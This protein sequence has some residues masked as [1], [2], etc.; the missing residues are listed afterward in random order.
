MFILGAMGF[1]CGG[2]SAVV[3]AV[4]TPEMI[5]NAPN[6][7]QIQ[8]MEQ[9]VGVPIRTLLFVTSAVLLLPGVLYVAFGVWVRGGSRLSAGFSLG[10][11]GLALL[12]VLLNMVGSLFNGPANAVGGICVMLIPLALLVTLVIWLIQAMTAAP[13]VLAMRQQF[14]SQYWHSQQQQ[15]AYHAGYAPPPGSYGGYPPVPGY[16]PPQ[17]YGPPPGFA[18]PPPPP[19]E[20]PVPGFAPPPPAPPGAQQQEPPLPPDRDSG[21]A[22]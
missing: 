8:Q 10:L 19:G 20:G 15:Q 5:A 9:Q 11:T 16:A 3:A 21:A 6:A 13:R 18:P 22:Q 1:L 12:L 14:Q 4:F 2:L 7:Q 17:G